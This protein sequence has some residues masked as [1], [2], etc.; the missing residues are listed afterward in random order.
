[1]QLIDLHIHTSASDGQV[2]PENIICEAEKA[3]LTF[4]AITD[5]DTVN[6]YKVLKTTGQLENRKL[7]VIPGIEFS[8]DFLHHE[9]HILGYYINIDNKVL[10]E[11]LD[12]LTADR[13]QRVNKMLEKLSY[14]GYEIT[15]EQV[16]SLTGP[17]N[18][19]VG[20]PHLAGALVKQGYFASVSEVFN[21]VLYTDGPAYVPHYKM[22]PD[23]IIAL[24]K[25][26]GG[27]PVLAHPGLIHDDKLV[28]DIIGKG[29]MGL[30]VYHPEHNANQIEAYLNLTKKYNLIATG[31][32]DFH[33]IT[34]RFPEKLGIFKIPFSVI[35]DLYA[36][37]A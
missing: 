9:V 28:I 37:L 31:G 27:I 7:S 8:A 17:I 21:Q 30:E 23:E 11:C 6:G 33:G 35:H 3:G 16:L 15:L 26:A 34:G 12:L 19:S 22:N 14:L 2:T 5:H 1:M 20:R 13:Q 10:N 4:I 32:S 24:I 18:K 29:I 36:V 25:T